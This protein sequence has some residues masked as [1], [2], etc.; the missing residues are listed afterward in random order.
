VALVAEAFDDFIEVGAAGEE[1]SVID[2]HRG[3]CWSTSAWSLL[4]WQWPVL[5]LVAAR[6]QADVACSV[7]A[8]TKRVKI[9]SY[10]VRVGHGLEG[11]EEEEEEE[12]GVKGGVLSC[13]PAPPLLGRR[14]LRYQEGPGPESRAA[15][16]PQPR[17][18]EAMCKAN[19]PAQRRPTEAV[20]DTLEGPPPVGLRGSLTGMRPESRARVMSPRLCSDTTGGE[21]GEDCEAWDRKKG[22]RR[23]TN[24]QKPRPGG[25]ALAF[26]DPRPGQSPFWPGLAWPISATAHG[27]KPGRNIYRGHLITLHPLLYLHQ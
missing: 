24:L 18:V 9:E 5:M 8:D 11:E 2:I 3:W 17:T 23:Q 25:P 15:E 6:A 4:R 1:V 27:L 21:A 10:S 19:W 16:A 13:V 26:R 14:P 7:D 12:E 20:W 22:Q